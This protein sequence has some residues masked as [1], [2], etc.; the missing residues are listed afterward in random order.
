MVKALTK[1][2]SF[3]VLKTVQSVLP[4]TTDGEAEQNS[5]QDLLMLVSK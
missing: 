2:L 1:V 3:K 5:Y 4:F